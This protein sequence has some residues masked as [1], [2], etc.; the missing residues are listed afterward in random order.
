LGANRHV[1]PAQFRY[2]SAARPA[3]KA[4][5]AA[6][7]SAF[8]ATEAQYAEMWA[9]DVAMMTSYAFSSTQATTPRAFTAAPQVANGAL[10]PRSPP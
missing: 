3:R 10:A 8:S 2:F 9:Q 4:A 1:T 6:F 5:G 7:D